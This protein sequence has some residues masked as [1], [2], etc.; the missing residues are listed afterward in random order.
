MSAGG[1]YPDTKISGRSSSNL[2]VVHAD[3][4]FLTTPVPE[5]Y[6]FYFHTIYD[7]PGVVASN[8]FLSV[9]NPV[10]SGKTLVFFQAEIASYT[11]GPTATATSLTVT[12]ITAASGG[13]QIAAASIGRFVTAHSNPVAEVRVSNPTVT[14]TGLALT[15]WVPPL[16]TG[17]STGAT[18][19]SSVPPGAGFACVPGEGIV[20]NT[21]AGDVDQVWKINTTWAEV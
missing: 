21:A 11:T 3:G 9:F 16:G 15:A 10:G 5:A 13:S 19:Y 20:F 17:A 6:R 7:A 2:A 14:T 1:Y 18:S 8:N 12:R 4:S